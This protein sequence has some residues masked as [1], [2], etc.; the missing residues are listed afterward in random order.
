MP[1]AVQPLHFGPAYRVNSANLYL[2]LHELRGD[3]GDLAHGTSSSG[4]CDSVVCA[5]KSRHL[6][7]LCRSGSDSDCNTVSSVTAPP[8]HPCECEHFGAR[9]PPRPIGS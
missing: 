5:R 3:E 2:C 4:N 8:S 1:V 7:V 9:F 6:C